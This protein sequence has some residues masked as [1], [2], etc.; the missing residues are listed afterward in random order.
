MWTQQIF[1]ILKIF[2]SFYFVNSFTACSYNFSGKKAIVGR[3]KVEA[4]KMNCNMK[5]F[6]F[7]FF[8]FI[9]FGSN[10]I[11]VKSSLFKRKEKNLWRNFSLFFWLKSIWKLFSNQIKT[12]IF[13]GKGNTFRHVKRAGCG[14][15]AVYFSRPSK[16][17]C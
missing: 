2:E 12:Q 7:C 10:L 13:G 1:I 5:T 4:T 3:K 8:F 11:S 15:H 16:K 9:F 6:P 14:P 17:C